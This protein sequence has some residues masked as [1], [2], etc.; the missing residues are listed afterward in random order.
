MV[1]C[2]NCGTIGSLSIFTSGQ[3]LTF[4]PCTTLAPNS[5][6]HVKTPGQVIWKWSAVSGA[7]GYRWN[8]V[9]DYETATDMGTALQ[10][11]ETGLVCDTTYNRFIWA[12]SS[13]GE[14]SVTTLTV[15]VPASPPSNLQS[16]TNTATQTGIAWKWHKVTGAEGYRWNTTNNYITAADNGT[17]TVYTETSLTCGTNYIRYVWAYNGC[18]HSS[19]LALAG[20]TALCPCSQPITDARDGKTY[21]IVLIGL[22]CWMAQNLNI[23]TRIDGVQAQTSNSIIEKYCQDDAENNC[24]TYGGLYQWDE[25]M[26]YITTQGVQG[27]CP[28]GWHL[29]TEMEWTTLADYLGGDTI[30]GGKMKET[31]LVHWAS[32]NAWATNSSGFTGFPAAFATTMVSSAFSQAT[33]TSGRRR[34]PQLYTRGTVT[35]LTISGICLMISFSSR[36]VCRFDVSRIECMNFLQGWPC[37]W[38]ENY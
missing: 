37:G 24:Q 15:S 5:G 29:P 17:D 26:Q 8:T 4:S 27:I 1:Y 13:C 21:T 34:S 22:Q 25:A 30:A 35:S 23:G 9:S 3:W 31:G 20:S 6:N 33:P 11:T 10:K 36:T 16:A 19:A 38:E 7:V 28:A 18:G 32:P 12:Y 14:S 2:T